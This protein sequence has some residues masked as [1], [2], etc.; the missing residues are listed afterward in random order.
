MTQPAFADGLL[1]IGASYAR[2]LCRSQKSCAYPFRQRGP[3]CY[4]HEA[5]WRGCCRKV[6]ARPEWLIPGRSRIFLVHRDDL[7]SRDLGK[8]FGYF[9]LARLEYTRGGGP[10]HSPVETAE[11]R[12]PGGAPPALLEGWVYRGD[13]S[14]P[15]PGVEVHFFRQEDET[16]HR[17][18]TDSRGGY[19]LPVESGRYQLTVE[20]PGYETVVFPGIQARERTRRR[21]DVYL[22]PRPCREGAELR[23]RCWD[24]SLMVTHRCVGGRWVPTD[25]ECPDLPEPPP[26]CNDDAVLTSQCWDGSEIITHVC[27]DGAWVATGERCPDPPDEDDGEDGNGSGG[28]GEGDGGQGEGGG[29]GGPG[30]GA[31]GQNGGDGP[32][33]PVDITLFEEHRSCSLRLK[34]RGVYL[35]DALTAEI[36]AAFSEALASHGIGRE[37]RQAANDSQRQAVVKRGRV[38]FREVVEAV[39]RERRPRTKIPA[40]LNEMADLRG[41]LVL[42]RRPVLME[43]FPTAAFRGLIR[44]DGDALLQ[45]VAAGEERP[46]I[47]RFR[48]ETAPLT[49]D[50]LAAHLGEALRFNRAAARR[51]LDELPEVARRELARHGTFT[52]PGVGRLEVRQRP[53]RRFRHP[54]TGEQQTSPARQVIRFIPHGVFRDWP[55][56]AD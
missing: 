17:T 44:I 6:P 5:E 21:Q 9:V 7:K 18:R 26:E 53:A 36:T 33:I 1:W 31:T 42:F 20:A 11:Y 41:E 24:D 29:K 27:R 23:R 22:H 32:E 46:R 54:V 40:A 3:H 50:G 25:E 15:L 30:G 47:P 45:Q 10:D 48:D 55:G 38:L 34:P 49:K 2:I 37:Y 28:A 4:V 51:F 39:R 8:I 16:V 43:V 52:L 35:V 12:P 56:P 13:R 19:R 14:R